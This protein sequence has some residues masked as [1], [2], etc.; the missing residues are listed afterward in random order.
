MTNGISWDL[1]A[2][3]FLAAKPYHMQLCP[4]ANATRST[5]VAAGF[6][7]IGPDFIVRITERGPAPELAL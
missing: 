2:L 4:F 5:L 3:R 7:E 1:K 6:A